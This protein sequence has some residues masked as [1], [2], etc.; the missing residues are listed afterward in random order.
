[1]K[2]ERWQQVERLYHAALECALDERAAFLAEACA[3]DDELCREVGELLAFDD[4]AASFIEKPAIEIAAR[5]LAD[6]LA[7]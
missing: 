5:A 3:G 7:G 4:L 2:V 6:D 1:M